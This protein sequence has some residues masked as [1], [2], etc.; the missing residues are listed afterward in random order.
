MKNC[1]LL[2]LIQSSFIF[3]QAHRPNNSI[4][5][6]GLGVGGKYSLNYERIIEEDFSI[7]VGFTAWTES[8]NG[9]GPYTA[10]PIMANYYLGF[11]DGGSKL[12]LGLGIEYAKTNGHGLLLGQP[13]G[14][15]V[16]GASAINYR[17]QPPNGGILYRIGLSQL[18][19]KSEIIYIPG[20]SIGMYF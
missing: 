20:I 15:S 13:T 17:Y 1:I 14:W 9:V 18:F 10:I 4:Y 11:G 6:E 2:L 19:D 5:L 3:A 12:E 16:F 8:F 7:R